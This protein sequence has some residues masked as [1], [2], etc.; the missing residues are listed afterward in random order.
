MQFFANFS[1]F[2]GRMG[3][4]D[5]QG[6]R[7]GKASAPADTVFDFP[8]QGKKS[9]RVTSKKQ[10]TGSESSESSSKY[11][12][13]R[14]GNTVLKSKLAEDAAVEAMRAAARAKRAEKEAMLAASSS[15]V[16]ESAPCE[17]SAGTSGMEEILAKAASGQKLTH[18]E[19]KALSAHEKAAAEEAERV[20]ET[21]AGLQSFS[22]S[23]PTSSTAGTGC[24]DVIAENVSISAPSKPLLVGANVRLVSGRRYGLLG[25]NGRYL[26][27]ASKIGT[28]WSSLCPI[29]FI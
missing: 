2:C 6:P 3:P 1:V 29:T 4:K 28:S 10:S 18:K 19:K 13:D 14:F 22:L 5:V 27:V 24:V 16:M 21:A 20:A 17:P 26:H 25:P 12:T 7:K 11:T 9:A 15:M 23:A 8:D